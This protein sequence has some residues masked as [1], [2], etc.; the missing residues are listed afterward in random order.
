MADGCSGVASDTTQVKIS[1]IQFNSPAGFAD[2]KKYALI[3]AGGTGLRM[4]TTV[5]KQFLLLRGRPV[6]WHT[7]TAFLTAF[8][9][10]QLVLV[11]PATHL[12]TGQSIIANL[13]EPQRIRITAGG[14]TR[15]QSVKNGLKLV[16]NESVVFVHDGVRCLVTPALIKR[17]YEAA[18]A[19]GN[20]V[21]ATLSVDSLRIE[22]GGQNMI[23]DRNQVHIIQTPQVFLSTELVKA[24]EQEYDICFTDE[25]SVVGKT[26]IKINLMEGEENNIKITRPMDLLMAEKILAEREGA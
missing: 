18:L 8:D 17:C 13:P 16:E 26:G 2:M 19:K 25:A 7:L 10:L 12:E 21:P 1:I 4:N 6:L 24:F 20:A 9:D 22:T 11:L 5:P 14:E 3:V 15:F 23:I